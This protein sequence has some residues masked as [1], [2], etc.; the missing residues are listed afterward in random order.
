MNAVFHIIAS[1]YMF[2][3]YPSHFQAE[4]LFTKEGGTYNWQY[5]CRLRD[6]ALH[7]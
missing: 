3:F 2:R 1:G 7:I 4:A 6:L 5:Y